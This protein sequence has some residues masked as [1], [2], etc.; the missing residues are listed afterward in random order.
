M[1]YSTT[2]KI[3]QPEYLQH[4]ESGS[5]YAFL[6]SEFAIYKGFDHNM[7]LVERRVGDSHTTERVNM[8]W[9][10]LPPYLK[11]YED[12]KKFRFGYKDESGKY[13]KGFTT[14]NATSEELL[15][16]MYKEAALKR[17]CL[18]PVHGFYEWMHVMVVGKSGKLLK[19]PE[20]FPYLVQMRNQE[21]FYL[22]AVWQPWFNAEVKMTINT[23]AI[24]T[25]DANTLMKQIHN[26][27]ERMPTILPVDLA[28]AWLYNDLSD[29]EILDIANYQVASAEMK[30]TPLHK[31]FLKR[32]DPHEEVIYKEAPELVYS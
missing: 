21:E 27:K 31:D 16:K 1:C 9:G 2:R 22:A 29:Q 4:L 28:E 17:R 13:H 18:I 14:L 23:F 8:Q 20:K 15:N 24:V 25:T 7:T 5:R 26:S 12:V 19:T 32:E 3:T 6:N 30:A 11:N 10:F